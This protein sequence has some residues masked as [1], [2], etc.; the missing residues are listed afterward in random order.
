MATQI[1]IAIRPHSASRY[2]RCMPA[3]PW[4]C[5]CSPRLSTA[6]S[7]CVWTWLGS[8]GSLHPSTR[9]RPHGWSVF[10]VR[11]QYRQPTRSAREG[12]ATYRCCALAMIA[13]SAC[14]RW[15]QAAGARCVSCLA[16]GTP[17]T[18]DA[19][20]SGFG[21]RRYVPTAGHPPR[22]TEISRTRLRSLTS[23]SSGGCLRRQRMTL[24]PRHI[25][26]VDPC[27]VPVVRAGERG[28]RACGWCS[29]LGGGV[30]LFG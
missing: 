29:P 7:A 10:D 16:A 28:E 18:K 27:R 5:L 4:C 3:S 1:Q 11:S 17:S 19:S 20:S 25:D 26:D 15:A 23:S 14:T 30:A 22:S 12:R 24:H 21:L 9:L 8:A 2:R 13:P 6:F